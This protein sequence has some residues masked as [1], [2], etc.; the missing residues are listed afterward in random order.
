[1]DVPKGTPTHE[2]DRLAQLV[3]KAEKNL[4]TKKVM[5]S[6]LTSMGLSQEAIDRLLHLKARIERENDEALT[7]KAEDIIGGAYGSS[8]TFSL[9]DSR[10]KAESL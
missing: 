5:A 1:V 9:G 4:M 2:G 8:K 3:D 6:E 7:C 10:K